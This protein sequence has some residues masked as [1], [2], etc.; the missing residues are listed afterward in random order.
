MH[1]FELRKPTYRSRA[2]DL[3]SSCKFTLDFTFGEKERPVFHSIWKF[4]PVTKPQFINVIPSSG[5]AA[6][7]QATSENIS[8][9]STVQ[10][11]TERWW[12]RWKYSRISPRARSYSVIAGSNIKTNVW[13]VYYHAGD[14]QVPFTKLGRQ[15]KLPQTAILSLRAPEQ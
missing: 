13:R 3:T 9:I 14:T 11:C 4:Q 6:S 5:T 7:S 2:R 8:H 10:L 15:L 1:P 12:D